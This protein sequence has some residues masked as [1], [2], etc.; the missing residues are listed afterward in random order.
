MEFCQAKDTSDF[1][2]ECVKMFQRKYVVITQV[3]RENFKPFMSLDLGRGTIIHPPTR[4]KELRDIRYRRHK[5]ICFLEST[6]VTTSYLVHYDTYLQ[7]A[8]DIITKCYRS[9]ITNCNAVLKVCYKMPQVFNY[10]M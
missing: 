4:C 10:K 1:I 8:T 6:V 9:F 2:L 3:S 7:N 5:G